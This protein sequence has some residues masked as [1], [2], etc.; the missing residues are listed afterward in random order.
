MSTIL[1]AGNATSGAV[2]SSDTAGSLQIQ[3]GSTPTTAVTIDTSQNV[4]IG[5]IPSA[6]NTFTAL[7]I[8]TY[9]SLFSSTG[10]TQLSGNLYY[11]SAY[12][13]KTTGAASV[14]VQTA[15]THQWYYA[16]S[17]SAGT[18]ATVSEAMRIDSSGNLLVGGTGQ[19]SAG[20]SYVTLQGGDN[21]CISTYRIG[22]GTRTHIAFYNGTAGSAT[23]VGTIQTSGSNTA[24]NTSSDYR[25]KENILPMTSA[26]ATVA[27]LKPVT[28]KW[29][30]DGSDGQGFIAHELQSV[31]PDCVS[32]EK[33]AVNEDGSIKPQG[34]DTSY[35]VATL[36]AAIQE[37]KAQ[38]DAQAAEIQALKGVA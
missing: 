34:I 29:K 4:G 10:S 32:G 30:I 35:L 25:L 33:D 1:Q 28:Y 2:V 37:L 18:T 6:W 14:Y 21:N 38:V 11:Q 24:Y 22:T 27:Q 9:S 3:T 7:D 8:N 13:Y 15:G 12:K 17:G 31:V 26:L 5:V 16:A 19:A 20:N 36:T 23:Q